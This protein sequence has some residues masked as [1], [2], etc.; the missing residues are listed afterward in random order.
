M[1]DQE[2]LHIYI[3]LVPFL[4]EV[5]GSGCEIVLHNTADPAHSLTAIQNS[6][7]GRQTGDALTD[8]GQELKAKGMYADSSYLAN[9]PGKGKG[10]DFLSSTYYIKNENRL[11]GLLC[12]NKDLSAVSELNHSIQN[13]LHQFNLNPAPE[14]ELSENLDTPMESL[15][16]RRILEL[17]AL[18]GR[19][20]SQM[21]SKEKAQIVCQLNEEGLMNVKGAAVQIAN[22]LSVSVPTVSRY[23]KN[24]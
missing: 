11:I 23:L 4:A 1:S 19:S 3:D 6:I 12:I 18:L 7:S 20:P 24:K 22:Q 9:Y 15:L 10:R 5:C 2:V 13:F 17:T 8:L 21:S 16:R 14:G